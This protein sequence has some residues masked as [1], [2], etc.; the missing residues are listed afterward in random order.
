MDLEIGLPFRVQAEEAGKVADISLDEFPNL[1][2][3]LEGV[4]AQDD[5]DAHPEWEEYVPTAADGIVQVPPALG[6]IKDI[7][8]FL[9]QGHTEPPDRAT[10][11]KWT[12]VDGL[13]AW[14][15]TLERI[16]IDTY[17][18]KLHMTHETERELFNSAKQWAIWPKKDD[19]AAAQQAMAKIINSIEYSELLPNPQTKVPGY[20]AQLVSQRKS[21]IRLNR[22][23]ELSDICR[24][25]QKKEYTCTIQQFKELS[26]PAAF[27]TTCTSWSKKK[28]APHRVRYLV[29]ALFF[30]PER[31]NS[32]HEKITKFFNIFKGLTVS[33]GVDPHILCAIYDTD[34]QSPEECWHL[35]RDAYKSYPDADPALLDD[36]LQHDTSV[37]LLDIDTLPQQKASKESTIREMEIVLLG[38]RTLRRYEHAFRYMEMYKTPDDCNINSLLDCY[39]KTPLSSK[40]ATLDVMRIAAE[41]NRDLQPK[42]SI[43]C[44]AYYTALYNYSPVDFLRVAPYP[45]IAQSHPILKDVNTIRESL[46]KGN[47]PLIGPPAIGYGIFQL[48]LT[49]EYKPVLIDL[50]I[51][52]TAFVGK[53]F[54]GLPLDLW[55]THRD[56]SMRTLTYEECGSLRTRIEQFSRTYYTGVHPQAPIK[57][58]A[59]SI[60]RDWGELK[61]LLPT[62]TIWF[63]SAEYLAQNIVKAK[64][65]ASRLFSPDAQ[66]KFKHLYENA[67]TPAE[68]AGRDIDTGT[69]KDTLRA[70]LTY[71]IVTQC[72]F[73]ANS[74]LEGAAS[75]GQNGLALLKE[76]EIKINDDIAIAL[77][78]AITFMGNEGDNDAYTRGCMLASKWPSTWPHLVTSSVFNR[79][80]PGL[81][82]FEFRQ[83]EHIVKKVVDMLAIAA[84]KT[85]TDTPLIQWSKKNLQTFTKAATLSR[86]DGTN[87]I[88]NLTR[89]IAQ[90]GLARFIPLSREDAVTVCSNYTRLRAELEEALTQAPP[91]FFAGESIKWSVKEFGK[92]HKAGESAWLSAYLPCVIYFGRGIIPEATAATLLQ[93]LNDLESTQSHLPSFRFVQNAI[94]YELKKEDRLGVDYILHKYVVSSTASEARSRA[95][96]FISLWRIIENPTVY[97]EELLTLK[98]DL[99]PAPLNAMIEDAKTSLA[100]RAAPSKRQSDTSARP[101]GAPAAAPKRAA[102]AKKREAAPPPAS[103]STVPSAG[104]RPSGAVPD[105]LGQSLPPH[106]R[107]NEVVLTFGEDEEDTASAKPKPRK[108]ITPDWNRSWHR[109]LSTWL[110][111]RKIITPGREIPLK[112]RNMTDTTGFAEVFGKVVAQN[113]LKEYNNGLDDVIELMRERIVAKIEDDAECKADWIYRAAL[114]KQAGSKPDFDKSIAIAAV[115]AFIQ[116]QPKA[117]ELFEQAVKRLKPDYAK[118]KG[119]IKDELE[120]ADHIPQLV[121]KTRIFGSEEFNVK[122]GSVEFNAR[123]DVMRKVA[124]YQQ[125]EAAAENKTGL[126]FTREWDD[127]S[128]A[129]TTLKRIMDRLKTEKVEA[130]DAVYLIAKAAGEDDQNADIYKFLAWVCNNEISIACLREMIDRM[131]DQR[132]TEIDEETRAYIQLCVENGS[133]KETLEK[134]EE[135]TAQIKGPDGKGPSVPRF[136]SRVAK[137]DLPLTSRQSDQFDAF[138]NSIEDIRRE[139]GKTNPPNRITSRLANGIQLNRGKTIEESVKANAPTECSDQLARE[140]A[141]DQ[142]NKTSDLKNR[143]TIQ[144]GAV[145]GTTDYETAKIARKFQQIRKKSTNNPQNIFILRENSTE[146]LKLLDCGEDINKTSLAEWIRQ[147][148]KGREDDANALIWAIMYPYRLILKDT[149]YHMI[150]IV[151]GGDAPTIIDQLMRSNRSLAHFFQKLINLSGESQAA[152][153]V[154]DL[155]PSKDVGRGTASVAQVNPPEKKSYLNIPSSKEIEDA[156]KRAIGAHPGKKITWGMALAELPEK[157]QAD[158]RDSRDKRSE[159]WAWFK[160]VVLNFFSAKR[161]KSSDDQDAEA[162]PAKRPRKKDDKSVPGD[163]DGR[164]AADATA[165]AAPSGEPSTSRVSPTTGGRGNV[166][167]AANTAV[168]VNEPGEGAEDQSYHGQEDRSSPAVDV[169]IR[170]AASAEAGSEGSRSPLYDARQEYDP[171][172]PQER[173]DY[174]RS[175]V[176]YDGESPHNK[177]NASK[178]ITE[179]DERQGEEVTDEENDMA[180]ANAPYAPVLADSDDDDDRA[181][182][183]VRP[184]DANAD[185]LLSESEQGDPLSAS[186][187]IQT[188]VLKGKEDAKTIGPGNQGKKA[189]ELYDRISREDFPLF[190]EAVHSMHQLTEFM[191]ANFIK[192]VLDA[193]ISVEEQQRCLR[194]IVRATTMGTLSGLEVEYTILDGLKMKKPK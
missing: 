10:V 78:A 73:T 67:F 3:S 95:E 48:H 88:R 147:M 186:E 56:D 148:W 66:D 122:Q 22:F 111:V 13:D 61:A 34:L 134:I 181:Y 117:D 90:A 37:D 72:F 100:E 139:E 118:E 105:S 51:S 16:L 171:P 156:A 82:R 108:R 65:W 149:I 142:E 193:K 158:L 128:M 45:S 189:Y 151:A 119:F 192:P 31:G 25:R 20:L 39:N 131:Q 79:K 97:K 69:A 176:D 94:S 75:I 60:S 74:F 102:Q 104:A 129:Y 85:N 187:Q 177:A 43:F 113:A 138:I 14:Q 70:V 28:E 99:Y 127:V 12:W 41:N 83:W 133:S 46:K 91:A 161:S 19:E 175:P 50:V 92:W 26:S 63:P 170:G 137:D 101:D 89:T 150:R 136:L 126:A 184:A 123:V 191:K 54:E 77:E 18:K 152:S 71:Q 172:S 114:L 8:S 167:P 153:A 121:S 15:R 188:S 124:R 6:T 21:A 164:E 130:S 182:A 27:Y 166:T 112:N 155:S 87:R 42:V 106:T 62:D 44:K 86:D 146:P 53:V 109:D 174:R 143:M 23:N 29:S 84:D 185:P 76:T 183:A 38:K 140:I 125:L 2:I 55:D 160:S 93:T 30:Q 157:A 17:K 68:S 144:V 5:D 81:V 96:P 24:K 47:S 115:I 132:G 180:E 107:T 103:A 40:Q 190:S 116:P 49:T 1:D 64:I 36:F 52:L 35:C 32:N 110:R 58:A 98:P 163:G 120:A 162:T 179:I 169:D 11:E 4:G 9:A 7:E 57:L 33:N 80:C 59:D 145:N 173:P 194:C 178:A 168:S 135:L 141:A 159:E 165:E 154:F